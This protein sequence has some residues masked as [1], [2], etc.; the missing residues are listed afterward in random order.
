M[1][2]E[3]EE[4]LC[5]ETIKNLKQINRSQII[6]PL[7]KAQKLTDLFGF[8]CPSLPIAFAERCNIELNS[9][10]YEE[11]MDDFTRIS[12]ENRDKDHLKNMVSTLKGLKYVN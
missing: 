6:E 2:I 11:E 9:K 1:K 4:A 7:A 3:T 10:M 5:Q 8:I 12:S